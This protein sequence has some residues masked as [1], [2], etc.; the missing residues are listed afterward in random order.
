[1]TNTLCTKLFEPNYQHART[2]LTPVPAVGFF[3]ECA[4]HSATTTDALDHMPVFGECSCR[5]VSGRASSD[6]RTAC[7]TIARRS[8]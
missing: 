1:M 7:S 5:M 3:L 4:G 8:V 6:R 2:E